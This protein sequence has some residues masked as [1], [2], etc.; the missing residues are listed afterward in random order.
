M[1]LYIK[2]LL[3]WL[4][5]YKNFWFDFEW[6]YFFIFL[7]NIILLYVTLDITNLYRSDHPY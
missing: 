4:Y 3:Y 5:V 6:F 7:F 2:Y 1:E